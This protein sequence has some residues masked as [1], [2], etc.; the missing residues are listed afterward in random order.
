MDVFKDSL[1]RRREYIRS[2][3][4][5]KKA[6][7]KI[8]NIARFINNLSDL[9]WCNRNFSFL[10]YNTNLFSIQPE[11][12]DSTLGTFQSISRIVELDHFC[13]ANVLLTKVRSHRFLF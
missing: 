5:F 1:E 4:S 2:H 13:D 7:F 6:K 8:E 11:L 9:I 12:L 10:I 3:H